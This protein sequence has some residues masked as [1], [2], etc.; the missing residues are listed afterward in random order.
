[1]IDFG[2]IVGF[3]WD[4]VNS[5]KGSEKHNVTQ[6]EADYIATRPARVRCTL[7]H[8]VMW[9]FIIHAKASKLG[10]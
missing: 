2:V 7:P 8:L 9:L 4:E 6:A 3:D 5:I 1:M 10:R